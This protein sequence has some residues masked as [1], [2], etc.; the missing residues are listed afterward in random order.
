MCFVLQ[1]WFFP[2]ASVNGKAKKML[3]LLLFSALSIIINIFI[4]TNLLIFYSVSFKIMVISASFIIK[5]ITPLSLNIFEDMDME[6]G[7]SIIRDYFCLQIWEIEGKKNDKILSSVIN[8][9]K[10]S[11]E[12]DGI[13]LRRAQS[14]SKAEDIRTNEQKVRRSQPDKP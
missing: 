11:G 2:L 7:R 10:M 13:R 1:L 6:K 3:Y 5:Q 14:V 9:C 4:I 12:Q 8:V